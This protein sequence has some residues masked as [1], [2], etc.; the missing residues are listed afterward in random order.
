MLTFQ[1]L[2]RVPSGFRCIY[3]LY[4][5][6]DSYLGLDQ[7]YE[8]HLNV[9]PASIAAQVNTEV[10]DSVTD[11]S[12]SWGAMAEKA[13]ISS[14]RTVPRTSAGIDRVWWISN[15][16]TVSKERVFWHPHTVMCHWSVTIGAFLWS[17]YSNRL[18]FTILLYLLWISFL[19][20][21][22]LQ[23]IISNIGSD[24]H[25]LLKTYVMWLHCILVYW[26]Y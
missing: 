7:Q 21:L 19:Y 11:L 13:I 5:M 8:I 16:V 25:L 15:T 9:T 1:L 26:S 3:T 18:E 24:L 4:L 6:S 14:R 12:L 2:I 10:S 23:V 20:L 22:L 17:I